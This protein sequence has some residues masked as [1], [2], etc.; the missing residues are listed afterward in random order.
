MVDKSE[1]GESVSR[2]I[3]VP[4]KETACDGAINSITDWFV[5]ECGHMVSR[6]RSVNPTPKKMYCG[7]CTRIAKDSHEHK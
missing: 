3:F 5:L 4:V 2:R 6:H 1:S 7:K